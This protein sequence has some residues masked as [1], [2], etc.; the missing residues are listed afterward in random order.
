MIGLGD[1]PVAIEEL[2][3]QSRQAKQEDLALGDAMER[4]VRNPDFAVYLR[5]VIGSRIDAFGQSLLEPAGGLDGLVRSEFLKGA[6]Y[7][8][9]LARDLPSVIVQSM[10]DIRTT[11]ENT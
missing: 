1:V 4:L 8:F 9:C 2:L 10:S 5:F 6:M 7:A 11:Q 3:R